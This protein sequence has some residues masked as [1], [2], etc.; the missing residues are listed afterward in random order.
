MKHN[1]IILYIT[2]I[3]LLHFDPLCPKVWLRLEVPR[4]AAVQATAGALFAEVASEVGILSG[5]SPLLC[6][7][8]LCLGL[9]PANVLQGF[10]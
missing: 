6:A 9:A 8:A 7:G 4:G 10:S 5:H 2:D 3:S 1:C